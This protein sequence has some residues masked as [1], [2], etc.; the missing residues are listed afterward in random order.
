M[1]DENVVWLVNRIG[2]GY[3]ITIFVVLGFVTARGIE[4]LM[5]R[6]WKSRHRGKA[7]SHK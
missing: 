4:H 3:A 2:A 5:I 6:W 1:E 7:D